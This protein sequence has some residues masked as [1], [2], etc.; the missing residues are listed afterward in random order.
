MYPQQQET[1]THFKQVYIPFDFEHEVIK[2]KLGHLVKQDKE[3][4]SQ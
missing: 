2:D 1:Y 4:L 3:T